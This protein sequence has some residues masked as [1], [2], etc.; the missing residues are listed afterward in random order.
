[1]TIQATM[2]KRQT[3]QSSFS[4]FSMFGENTRA[5]R[6]ELL[7]FLIQEAIRNVDYQASP[8]KGGLVVNLP[9][10][11]EAF[12]FMS[13]VAHIDSL[14]EGAQLETAVTV[15]EPGEQSYLSTHANVWG[16]VGAC[17]S[18][19]KACQAILYL[20][21][22]K[23]S[24]VTAVQAAVYFDNW[25]WELVALNASPY[26]EPCPQHPESMARN[27]LELPGGSTAHYTSGQWTRSVHYWG[28]H[29][30]LKSAEPP[31]LADA[32]YWHE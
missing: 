8:A 11:G 1:M 14:P 16:D 15:R 5:Q 13:P 30:R 19:A 31:T 32:H 12:A 4:H 10:S 7:K 25:D 9:P 24:R 18:V 21:D 29:V 6:W 17:K 2:V 22:P 3:P 27:Q 28:S 23:D 26:A 20:R